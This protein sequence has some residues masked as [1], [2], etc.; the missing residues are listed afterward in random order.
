MTVVLPALEN[1]LH[2]ILHFSVVVIS[3]FCMDLLLETDQRF[4]VIVVAPTRHFRHDL[5][6]YV[7]LHRLYR[8]P[9]ASNEN[10]NTELRIFAILDTNQTPN[11]SVTASQ[12]RVTELTVESQFNIQHAKPFLAVFQTLIYSEHQPV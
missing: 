4:L 9:T 3:L 5:P 2:F 8:G 12:G 10:D 11:V 7:A 6:P 1:Q